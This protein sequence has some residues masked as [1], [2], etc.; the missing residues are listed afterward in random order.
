MLGFQDLLLLLAAW[1]TDGDGADLAEPTDDVDFQD[2]LVLL[3]SWGPC[4]TS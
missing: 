3:S 1:G 4:P 2:L